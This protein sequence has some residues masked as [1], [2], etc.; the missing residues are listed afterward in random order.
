MNNDVKDVVDKALTSTISRV[1]AALTVPISA[2]IAAV[3]LWFQNSIGIDLQVD[4]AVAATFVGTIVLGGALLGV[5]W[6][7]GR[8]AFEKVAGEIA[9]AF[10]VGDAAN[11]SVDEPTGTVPPGLE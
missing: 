11:S 1:V 6:L 3:L 5:K 7:E 8:A 10:H 9:L 4:P 2:V